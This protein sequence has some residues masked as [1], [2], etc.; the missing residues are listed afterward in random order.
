MDT[1]E[2]IGE[3]EMN[4]L[5]QNLEN[6]ENTLGVLKKLNYTQKL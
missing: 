6:I 2:K 1:I 4:K 5:I 3:P